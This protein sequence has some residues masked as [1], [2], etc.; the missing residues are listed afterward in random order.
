M[1][2]TLIVDQIQKTGGSTTA[3]TLPTSNAS[4][5]QYL[6][7]DGAGALSWATVSIPAGGKILQVI[8]TVVTASTATTTSTSFVDITG[9]T[10]SITPSAVTS[11]I[12]VSCVLQIG[13]ESGWHAH[14]QLVRDSTAI[15][16]GDASGSRQRTTGDV[17]Y[18]LSTLNVA[19]A[20]FLDSPNTTSATTYKVQWLA[21]NT[22]TIYLNRS[23]TNT[24]AV[25]F[26]LGAS[27]ITAMEVGA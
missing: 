2:S 18:N 23:Y 14:Y 11:K 27:T 3:L 10:L 22:G 21:E 15:C 26:P 20:E 24:D 7:N 8:Q 1:A 5:S 17:G 9:M 25:R 19:P 6:Q 13:V 12:L 16:I 4:A